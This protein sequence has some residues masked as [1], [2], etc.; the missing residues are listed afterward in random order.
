ME[1]VRRDSQQRFIACSGVF[2]DSKA[3]VEFVA[4][5]VILAG[6]AL[7]HCA[8]EPLN[9]KF[10]KY[11]TG[12]FAGQFS[13]LLQKFI[14]EI[15]NLQ[16]KGSSKF[17]DIF[18]LG[19]GVAKG[20]RLL[21]ERLPKSHM[22]KRVELPFYSQNFVIDY[23]CSKYNI[24]VNYGTDDCLKKTH[25]KYTTATT[26]CADSHATTGNK[27]GF[28]SIDGAI[29]ENVRGKAIK[30]TPFINELMEEFFI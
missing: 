27:M 30:F 3:Y 23:V 16:Y 18:R 10:L 19:Q 28:G 17:R 1:Q 22:I 25:C 11:G 21:L 29:A 8:T 13:N 2:F 7:N 20:L 12:Y 9:F 15:R 4:N 5:D 14:G 26:N 24:E 6:M